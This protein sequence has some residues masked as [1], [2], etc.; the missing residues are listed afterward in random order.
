MV[1]IVANIKILWP[2]WPLV[3]ALAFAMGCG[4]SSAPPESSDQGEVGAPAV[5]LGI[6]VGDRIRPFTLRLVDGS[7]LTSDT[8]LTQ[9]QPTLLFFFK[10]G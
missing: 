5:S 2:L 3:A 9:N 7:T 10:K 8:L 1:S 6:Q 4:T